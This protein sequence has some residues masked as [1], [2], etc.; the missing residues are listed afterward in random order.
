VSQAF[1][2]ISSLGLTTGTSFAKDGTPKSSDRQTEQRPVAR[3][4]GTPR[5][6]VPQRTRT[7]LFARMSAPQPTSFAPAKTPGPAATP[8]LSSGATAEESRAFNLVNS[9][10]QKRG[11]KPLVWDA[12]LAQ[13]ARYHSATM[14]HDGVLSHID[15]DGLNLSGRAQVLGLHGWRAL[16]ENVAYN[17]GFADPTAFA[18]ERWMISQA[19]RENILNGGFTHAGVGIARAADGRVFFT[20]VFMER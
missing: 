17:Q 3:L 14:A 19:H 16:G 20:Q 13:L 7:R 8:A 15:R 18:V 11:L 4:I 5:Q 12:S 2:L 10:R 1:I 9:E 6:E